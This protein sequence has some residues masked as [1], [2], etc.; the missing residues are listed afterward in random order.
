MPLTKSL[1]D[2]TGETSSYKM[3]DLYHFLQLIPGMV[4]VTDLEA[5]ITFIN[6]TI[7]PY[8]TE[9]YSGPHCLDKKS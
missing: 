4:F 7:P 3:Q 5:N 1:F 6:K 8:K 2:N 9:E